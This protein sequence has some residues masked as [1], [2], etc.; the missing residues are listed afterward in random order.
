MQAKAPD[1]TGAST[2]TDATTDTDTGEPG[3]SLEPAGDYTQPG[4]WTAGQVWNEITGTTGATLLISTWFPSSDSGSSSTW[5]GW[6]G[7]WNEGESYTDVTPDCT[8]PRPVMVHSHGISSLSWEMFYLPEFLSTHGWIVVAPD[9]DGNTLYDNTEA[10]STLV[11]RRP[12]DLKDT[13]NWLVAQSEDPTS[14]FY[15]CVDAAD[16]YVAAGYSFGGY[17]AY[18][19]GGAL[20]NDSSGDATV[21]YSDDRVT[22]IVTY[23]PWNAYETLTTG[24]SGIDVPVLTIGGDSDSTVGTQYRSLHSQIESTPRLLGAFDNVGHYSFTPI[25]CWGWGDGCG[26]YYFDQ[27]TFVAMVKPTVLSWIEHIRGREGAIEQIPEYA[28]EV[29]WT[30]VE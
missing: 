27:D 10:F 24:T 28:G 26:P 13:Y 14:G 5:Y 15:G 20:V 25:Y 30:L 19:T 8:E 9:H 3:P 1:D 17:T 21:D 2:D 4:E 18:A 11:E 23:A 7:F 29:T 22:G 16:G 12:Q 6:T